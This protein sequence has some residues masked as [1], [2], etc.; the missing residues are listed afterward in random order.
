M[1]NVERNEISI[2]EIKIFLA[3]SKEWKTNKEIS[4]LSGVPERT[5]RM[6]THWFV[7]LGI[8]DLAEVFPGHR[9]RLSEKADKRNFSYFN[10]LEHAQTV[11]GISAK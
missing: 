6:H 7:C 2:Q 10:R 11:F 8:S 1:K 3:L 5:V 4:K 9:F